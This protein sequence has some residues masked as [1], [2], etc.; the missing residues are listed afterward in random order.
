MSELV[1]TALAGRCCLRLLVP[2]PGGGGLFEACGRWGVGG[3]GA[4]DECVDLMFFS[5]RVLDSFIGCRCARSP[6]AVS[7]SVSSVRPVG[8]SCSFY[9]VVSL[10]ARIVLI[11]LVFHLVRRLVGRLVSPSRLACSFRSSHLRFPWGVSFCSVP[12][13]FRL[14]ISSCRGV[15]LARLVSFSFV[16]L[17]C[18]YVMRRSCV[19]GC[20]HI[21]QMGVR[22]VRLLL[23]RP[24]GV[25]GIRCPAR[26]IRS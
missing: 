3:E 19:G 23:A 25:G 12:P 13:S 17:P 7:S 14:V 1:E 21:I 15:L 26:V 2:P 24:D 4:G 22:L 8:A 20:S 6:D 16:L 11:R 10:L 9:P 5:P 18:G